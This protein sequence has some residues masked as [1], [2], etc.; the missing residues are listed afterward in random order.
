MI[1]ELSEL[2]KTIR[3][4]KTENECVH[5]ALKEEPISMEIVISEDGGFQKFESFEKKQTIAE[6]ITAKKGKA[7]LLLDKAEE[8]FC[9]GGEV[10]GK[11]HKLFLEKL[12]LYQELN[13]LK[14]V[15]AFY[16]QNK[17]NGLDKA[18][19][20]FEIAIP[21]EKNR[22]GNI[23][24]RI[25]SEGSRIHEK[26]EVLK[27]IIAEYET[28]QK[29]LLSTK[30]KQCSICGKSDY[31]VEDIPHGMIKKVPDG[32]T[33]G[34][35]LVSYNENAF[36]SYCLK[37][38]NN[39]SVCTNCAKTYVEGLNWFLSSGNEVT[40][41]TKK[42][43]EKKEF[44]YTNRRNFGSDTAMVFWTR[45]NEK[46]DEIDYLEAPNPADV[47]RLIESVTSGT[48]RDNRYIEPDQF[49]SCT[50]SGSAARI[51]VRDWIETSLFEF[52]KS[53]AMWFQ[54][55]AID[56]Y[57]SDL[58]KTQSHYSRLYDLAR[59]CQRKN[60]DGSYDKDGASLARVATYLWNIALKNSTPPHWILTKVLQRARL[61]GV[62][63]ER[64]A[65]IKLILN[66]NNKGGDFVITEKIE[67]GNR[68][69]AYVC[70]Q[71]FAKLESVQYAA[72]GDRNAGIRERYFTYMLT[73]PSAAFG[74]LF[75]LS[76]KHFRKLKNEK[77]GLAVTLDKELQDLVKDIDINKL[78]A[79]FSLEEKGQFA[80]GYYHQRQAQFDNLKSKENKEEE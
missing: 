8:M 73:L 31:P 69:V 2:G 79:T 14:P 52:R 9:Y 41:K 49:Y 77:P 26:P 1:K 55:I 7:R 10:S 67:Q 12:A 29:Q 20:E 36:E 61:D 24:F 19:K 46:L 3:L 74:R 40:I 45:K 35:A 37:G 38:N 64:A 44:R 25:Q 76:S 54:D 66:R 6:A 18:L 48:E 75:D 42:G 47:A 34:C 13:E 51:A 5:N 78:P 11:K 57:N 71:I 53:I 65:L 56:E 59:C 60:S 32:Q 72:L 15:V 43:K 22:K 70:G 30:Q 28:A 33:S 58:M 17:V 23:G 50:L 80:I 4:G 62:T 27:R 39:S 16:E 68:P 21:D 63:A